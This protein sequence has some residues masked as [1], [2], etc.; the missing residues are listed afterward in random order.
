MPRVLHRSGFGGRDRPWSVDGVSA[1]S[2]RMFMA[3]STLL[4]R[5]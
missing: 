2:E 1:I 4:T 3:Q 5:R